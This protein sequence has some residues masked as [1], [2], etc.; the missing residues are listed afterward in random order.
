LREVSIFPGFSFTEKN[1][2]AG[3]NWELGVLAGGSPLCV[4]LFLMQCG[5]IL[6]I[7]I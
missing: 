5:G 7:G 6:L 2:R 3:V 4:N 1:V